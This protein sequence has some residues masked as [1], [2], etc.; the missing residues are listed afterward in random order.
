MAMLGHMQEKEE[1]K[2][3][4]KGKDGAGTPRSKDEELCSCHTPANFP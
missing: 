2:A 3:G 1:E 4:G